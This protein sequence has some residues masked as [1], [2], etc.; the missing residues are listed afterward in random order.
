[1]EDNK[2][3]ALS[4]GTEIPVDDKKYTDVQVNDI[5][6]REKLRAAEAARREADAMH[7]EELDRL[8]AEKEGNAS[9]SGSNIDESAIVKRV[10]E[11]FM[12]D[13]QKHHEKV[14]AEAQQQELK[15]IADQYHLKMGKGSELFDDF[16]EVMGDFE[17]HNFPNVV[18]LTAQM[19]NV[20]EIMYELANNPEKLQQ[21]DSLAEKSPKLALKQLEKLS[22]SITKNLQAKQS[23]V[24]APAP[25]SRLKSSS[26]GADSGSMTLKDF[27]NADWLRG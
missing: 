11:E 5:V 16:Q 1:M 23:S 21:I 26:V 7:R 2:E 10:R 13:L 20:P 8:R 27:K 9:N 15:T 25:L 4:N 19:E 22:Q 14:E 18:M 3:V 24:N 6:K 17:P 12:T